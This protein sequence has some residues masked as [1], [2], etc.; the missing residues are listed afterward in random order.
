MFDPERSGDTRRLSR[1]FTLVELLVVIGVIALLIAILLPALQKA[2]RQAKLIQCASNLRQYGTLLQLYA[3]EHNRVVPLFYSTWIG[4]NTAN[5]KSFPIASMM[6]TYG[7]AAST[8]SNL[9]PLGQALFTTRYVKSSNWLIFGCPLQRNPR[10]IITRPPAANGLIGYVGYAV[11]PESNYSPVINGSSQ[12]TGFGFSNSGTV[13]P[14]YPKITSFKS[15]QA[16]ASDLLVVRTT[17][18]DANGYSAWPWIEQTH[19][20]TNCSVFYADGSVRLVPY[21]VYK[22]SYFA[23][24]SGTGLTSDI[25][26]YASTTPKMQRLVSGFWYDFD[27]YR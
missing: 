9:T 24:P 25:M 27:H 10:F 19:L 22:A 3:T 5:G 16:L 21:G 11:R 1:A 26:T 15:N 2:K 20:T 4:G 13:K 17:G 23:A 18:V 6:M 8:N 7:T 14:N 12:V